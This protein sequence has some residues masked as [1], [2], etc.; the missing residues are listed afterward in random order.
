MVFPWS[1]WPIM[2]I[3]GDFFFCSYLLF[4]TSA[5]LSWVSLIIFIISNYYSE[6]KLALGF[7]ICLRSEDYEMF[8]RLA[9]A[10]GDIG[11]GAGGITFFKGTGGFN[12]IGG[13]NFIGSFRKGVVAKFWRVLY[14]CNI[15]N[16]LIWLW[17]L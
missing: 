17:L 6:S 15:K 7:I 16:F 5:T 2:V 14:T 9:I 8:R 3:T 12:A 13:F 4:V 11:D 10:V 1:T